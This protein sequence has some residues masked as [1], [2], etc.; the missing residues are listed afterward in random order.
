MGLDSIWGEDGNYLTQKSK[1]FSARCTGCGCCSHELES[2]KDVKEEAIN[3]LEQVIRASKYFKW[4]IAELVKEA[5]KIEAK[6][7]REAQEGE[8][9]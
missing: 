7:I 9:K 1:G 2:E 6:R 5:G 4:N 8:K 3:S